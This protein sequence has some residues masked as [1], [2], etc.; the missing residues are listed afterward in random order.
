MV[1]P[2]T[3]SLPI[4]ANG[5]WQRQPHMKYY[6]AEWLNDM[7][8]ERATWHETAPIQRIGAAYDCCAWICLV[9]L[10]AC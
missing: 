2:A 8:V 6:R 4:I 7:L 10:L 3:T 9:S 5:D 1:M